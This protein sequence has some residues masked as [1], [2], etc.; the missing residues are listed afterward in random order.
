MA[1][2][3][4]QETGATGGFD[5]QGERQ[6]VVTYAVKTNDRTDGPL[7]VVTSASLPSYLAS[8]TFQ[9]EFDQGAYRHEINATYVNSDGS[10]K[11]WEVTATFKSRPV[12]NPD[13]NQ[14]DD[15]LQLRAEISGDFVTTQV[16][17]EYDKNGVVFRNSADDRF[18]GLVKDESDPVLTITQNYASISQA[19]FNDYINT[20]NASTFWGMPARSWKLSAISWKELY[21][22]GYYYAV[23]YQFHGRVDT[24]DLKPVDEGPRYW[25]LSAGART[26]RKRFADD[27]GMPYADGIGYLDGAVGGKL[28]AGATPIIYNGQGGNPAA[29]QVYDELEFAILGIPTDITSV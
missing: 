25:E 24:W 1:V 17:A 12:R 18:L 2:T 14:T 22:N 20:V 15:P 16:P 28:A 21:R 23:T 13:V 27:D 11:L 3:S 4:V 8:Y 7:L 26:R 10:T 6:W 5:E 9:N 19:D 29:F